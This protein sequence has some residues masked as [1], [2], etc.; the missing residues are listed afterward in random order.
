MSVTFAKLNMKDEGS[1]YGGKGEEKHNSVN[2][3]GRHTAFK[4]ML[5][6]LLPVTAG[7]L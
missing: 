3:L 4:L 2:D 7:E 1:G 5:L 6:V